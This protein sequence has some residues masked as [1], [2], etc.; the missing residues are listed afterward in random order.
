MHI[1]RLVDNPLTAIDQDRGPNSMRRRDE[2]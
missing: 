1:H 2:C